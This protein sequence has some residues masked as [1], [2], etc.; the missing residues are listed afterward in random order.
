MSRP[1]SFSLV[2]SKRVAESAI[3]LSGFNPESNGARGE[4]GENYASYELSTGDRR[5]RMRCSARVPGYKAS[6]IVIGD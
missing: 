1:N 2:G 6:R 3:G 5:G 4:C